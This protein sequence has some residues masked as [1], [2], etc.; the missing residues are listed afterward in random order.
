MHCFMNC[1]AIYKIYIFKK[2]GPIA[3]NKKLKNNYFIWFLF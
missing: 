2:G 1:P 3:K